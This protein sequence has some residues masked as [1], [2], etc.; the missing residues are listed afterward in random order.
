MVSNEEVSSCEHFDYVEVP[1]WSPLAGG[2]AFP[3]HHKE[4]NVLSTHILFSDARGNMFSR[5]WDIALKELI[6]LRR[7]RRILPMVI[8]SPVLQLFIYGYAISTTVSNISTAIYDSDHSP[9]SRALIQS[10]GSSGYFDINRFLSSPKDL[11][12]T[13]DSGNDTI[14]VVIP[15]DFQKKLSRRITAP[16][17]VVVD[18]S[19]PNT[20]TTG[21]GYLASIFQRYS[22]KIVVQRLGPV[23]PAG[24]NA[25]IRVWYNPTLESRNYMVPGIIALI[26]LQITMNLTAMSIVKERERGTIEQLI[27]TPIRRYE[28]VLGKVLP[29]AA[30]GYLDVF[31]VLLVG[32]QAFGVPVLGSIPLLLL[33][34][35]V[36]LLTALGIGLFISTVSKNQQQATMAIAFIMLPNFL[37]SGFFYP[38][39]NMPQFIQVLTYLIPLRYYLVIVRSIFLKGTGMSALWPQVL[40]M[41]ILGL[42]ILTGAVLGFR[43]KL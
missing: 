8:I 33:L 28:L 2:R 20:A 26:M 24:V 23:Q 32:T 17:Q 38:T 14:A 16:I 22:Q 15:R 10:I 37:L 21:L 3:C 39:A 1:L 30:I 6:Q 35:G 29:Y 36:F 43:K 41:F 12:A 13:I 9:A 40:P 31:L 25:H 19:D 18:G 7:D 5:V 4:I 11:N 27:V 34:T 42:V